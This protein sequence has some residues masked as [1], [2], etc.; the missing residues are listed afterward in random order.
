MIGELLGTYDIVNVI[1]PVDLATA[2]NQGKRVL[3]AHSAWCTLVIHKAAGTAGQDPT[4]D[5]Q[6]A[7]AASGGTEKD[8][9]VVAY[10]YLKS[11]ATLDGDEAWVK[12]TQTAASEIADPGGDGTSAES[13]QIIVIEIDPASMDI[14]NGF[15]WITIDIPD[16]GAAAQL[17]ACLAILKMT[18]PTAPASLPAT[19]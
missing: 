2:A 19:Q 9:D 6:Q 12:E 11:E 7:D 15:K 5:V 17:G 3:I 14:A 1:A 10:Y 16:P 13:E 8:L 4:I 18:N